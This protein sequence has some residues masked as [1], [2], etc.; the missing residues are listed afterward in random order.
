MIADQE[1]ISKLTT[2]I[3]RSHGTLK[4]SIIRERE[5]RM[6]G[7]TFLILIWRRVVVH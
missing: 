2:L 6:S 5:E 7:T 4:S 3:T 1:N